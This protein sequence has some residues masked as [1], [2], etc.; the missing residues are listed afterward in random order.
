MS[1]SRLETLSLC[2]Q[3]ILANKLVSTTEQLGELTI[4]VD[5]GELLWVMK[6]LRDNSE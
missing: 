4:E 5:P 2:L 6:T 3:N 1:L